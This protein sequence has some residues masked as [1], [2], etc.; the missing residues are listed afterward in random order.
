MNSKTYILFA[1]LFCMILSACN[2]VQNE[3][4]VNETITGEWPPDSI[5][6][7]EQNDRAIWEVNQR[8][9]EK[10]P[11]IF[12]DSVRS[13]EKPP[14][15]FRIAVLGD[16]FIWGDGINYNN[17][18]S[19]KLEQKIL[20][21]YSNIE[22]MSWGQCGWSTQNE[23][24]FFIDEGYKYDIDLLLVGFV[25]NDLDIEPSSMSNMSYEDFLMSLYNIENLKKYTALLNKFKKIE[26][27]YKLKILFV[28]TPLCIYDKYEKRL[29]MALDCI[30]TAG[31]EYLNLYP[32]ME[33][34]F[35]GISCEELMASPINGHPGNRLT[36]FFSDEVLKFLVGKKY[37]KPI[38]KK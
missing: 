38:I 20:K 25:D 5:T 29:E 2:I 26:T 17:V 35:N 37:F 11:Y 7:W 19:H 14:N 36:S 23:Y 32:I 8:F 1:F 6:K 15:T 10:N 9:A 24:T 12:T 13:Y 28:I 16:S 34:K 3:T 21:A 4:A 30:N 18:W 33:D 31:L 22:V 27:D